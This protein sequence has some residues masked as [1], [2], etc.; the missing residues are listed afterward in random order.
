MSLSS[1]EIARDGTVRWL[2]TRC[3]PVR[4]AKN[5]VATASR[6]PWPR[7]APADAAPLAAPSDRAAFYR[8]ERGELV[9]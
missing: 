5:H 8:D 6:R 4:A 7:H 1:S 9:A 2:S 3:S